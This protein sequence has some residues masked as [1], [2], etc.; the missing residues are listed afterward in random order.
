MYTARDVYAV[1]TSLKYAAAWKESCVTVL[2]SILALQW[3]AWII[4]SSISPSMN[5]TKTPGPWETMKHLQHT[6]VNLFK[7]YEKL[8]PWNELVTKLYFFYNLHKSNK[9][10]AGFTHYNFKY[11]ANWSSYCVKNNILLKLIKSIL[12]KDIGLSV[13]R[14]FSFSLCHD[15]DVGLLPLLKSMLC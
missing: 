15:V 9:R 14:L 10:R 4:T 6:K 3:I 12:Q 2:F 13:T 1:M 7:E 5:I 11:Q 8:V